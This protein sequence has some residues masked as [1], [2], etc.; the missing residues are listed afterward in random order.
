[1]LQLNKVLD[2]FRPTRSIMLILPQGMQPRYKYD[3]KTEGTPLVVL[4]KG[5]VCR[6]DS[7]RESANILAVHFPACDGINSELPRIRVEL[8]PTALDR[9]K[10]RE[11]KASQ[12]YLEPINRILP[13]ELT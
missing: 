8:G 5:C 11:V 10:V 3:A 4:R 12:L 2:Y 13:P 6:R 1:M 7:Y 9:V